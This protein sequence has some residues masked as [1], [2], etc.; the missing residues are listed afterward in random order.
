MTAPSIQT[1]RLRSERTR[2]KCMPGRVS[3]DS[4]NSS[5]PVTPQGDLMSYMG[6]P[7]V[8][9]VTAVL[10][11]CASELV[12]STHPEGLQKTVDILPDAHE[13]YSQGDRG[14][15]LCDV[16]TATLNSSLFFPSTATGKS[17]NNGSQK[18]AEHLVLKKQTIRYRRKLPAL[19]LKTL[20]K[21]ARET[22]HPHDSS[23]KSPTLI[24]QDMTSLNSNT[25][26][27]LTDGPNAT[28]GDVYTG[29]V[30]HALSLL[31]VASAPS[32]CSPNHKLRRKKRI[33]LL[34]R[35]SSLSFRSS[36]QQSFPVYD[37]RAQ[38]PVP[39]AT[40]VPHVARTHSPAPPT[41]VSAEPSVRIG[42]P[43]RPYYTAIR[44]NMSRPGTPVLLPRTPSPMPSDYDYAPRGT[45][46]LD[47]GE[48][49][50]V[51]FGRDSRPMSMVIPGQVIPVSL[52]SGFSLSGE[53][54]MRM[55]LARWRKED[56]PDEPGDYLFKETG[57][58]GKGMLKGRVKKLGKG[59]R[60]LMLGRS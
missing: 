20:S 10:D 41:P 31:S 13:I 3:A 42:H 21:H 28:D 33:P 39:H 36:S 43:S 60:D 53:T 32:P 48:R 55:N 17:L 14:D 15:T 34:N 1:S 58:F 35:M 8:P 23:R 5:G 6:G 46:S 57:R 9:V 22:L 51:Q 7:Q 47:C 29:G 54:E 59:L 18:E 19:F 26:S 11:S 24:T 16:A 40:Q 45:K 44:K 25:S 30:S 4:T 27:I 12:C 56:A 49:T 2:V 52:Y 38:S 37:D 50:P